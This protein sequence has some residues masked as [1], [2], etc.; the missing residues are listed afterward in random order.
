MM[1]TSI[2][3]SECLC[4]FLSECGDR[5][6]PF[7]LVVYEEITPRIGIF[8]GPGRDA[9]RARPEGSVGEHKDLAA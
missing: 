6:F 7:L 8:S 9:P 1:G 2:F 4:V 3:T 5:C